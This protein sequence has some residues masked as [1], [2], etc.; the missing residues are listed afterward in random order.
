MIRGFL[1]H[2][3]L[4]AIV[5]TLIALVLYGVTSGTALVVILFSFVGLR[6]IRL[7]AEALQTRATDLVTPGDPN[8]NALLVES[9]S[10]ESPTPSAPPRKWFRSELL[11]RL[12]VERSKRLPRSRWE[13][14]AEILGLVAFVLLIPALM[15][16]NAHD[17]FSLR[18]PQG[19]LPTAV[20]LVCV[21]L[22]ACPHFCLVASRFATLRA[23]WWAIPF[24]P[25]LQLF[26]QAIEHRHPYLN[27]FNPQ[28]TRLAAERVLSLKNN[29]VAGRHADWVLRYARQLDERGQTSEAIG[30]YREA[31]RLDSQNQQTRSR[32]ASLEGSP[33]NIRNIAVHAISPSAPYWSDDKS[34][35]RAPRR[36]IDAELKNLD[37][38]TVILVPIG[39][40]PEHVLDC[41]AYA[42]NKELDLPVYI[43]S[44]PVALPPHTRVR[45]L[46]TGS[47]W[48]QLTL[49]RAFLSK[50]NPPPATPVKYLLV[51][52]VDIYSEDVNYTFSLSYQW[53]GLISCARFGNPKA[54]DETLCHRS[55]KQA[56]CALIKSFG[57]PPSPNHDCVT[58]YTHDLRE[59]D[60][61]GNRP[62]ADTLDAFRKAVAGF[63]DGWRK[64][65]ATNFAEL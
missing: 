33:M 14:A 13:L 2:H 59:F 42:V 55:A 44:E 52:P 45:G 48:D 47:Q 35:P 23:A 20:V 56:L 38:C 9:R 57:I 10:S 3:L 19:W 63:N 53:G 26:T 46:V 39:D 18:T 15:A 34:I 61:K 54:P 49:V 40:L 17:F 7:F 29:V 43:S 41:V 27:P 12:G 4:K 21:G 36:T 22:Y 65:K 62:D 1:A 8:P 51:A 24:F 28:H 25:A 30:F 50:N 31:L 37:A 11:T 64:Y 6:L 60:S 32:L 16:L 5:F 58:S